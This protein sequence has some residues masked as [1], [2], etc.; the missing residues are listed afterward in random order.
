MTLNDETTSA[1]EVVAPIADNA[2]PAPSDSGDAFDRS[3]AEYDSAAG[4]RA[5]KDRAELDELLSEVGD[6]TPAPAD[7]VDPLDAILGTTADQQQFDALQQREQQL[8]AELQE[9]R[10]REHLRQEK[11]A[12]AEFSR[13][14]ISKM[15]EEL[16]D[17][18]NF[19]QTQLLALAV[20][21]PNVRAAFDLR[22]ADVEKATQQ[23]AAAE[24][25]Y[26]LL[27][28]DWS[29]DPRKPALL[30]MLR[31]RYQEAE[32][33]LNAKTILSRAQRHIIDAGRR[34]ARGQIDP[35]ATEDREAVAQAVRGAG[36]KAP[37]E[38]S[39]DVANM[40][41]GEFESYKRKLFRG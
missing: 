32:I 36:G 12:F 17:R 14:I 16:A 1:D 22:N 8:S 20:T 21:E 7:G 11:E 18:E 23:K 2:S 25:F 31:Q 38:P 5:E 19:V 37:P 26:T 35:V 9:A 6:A 4:E 30:Q 24:H 40:P 41:T 34:A 13:E 3:L 29:N 39:P 28:N 15:P 27:M 10:A 33:A